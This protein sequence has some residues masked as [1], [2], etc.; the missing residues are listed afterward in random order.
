MATTV[1]AVRIGRVTRGVLANVL[2]QGITACTQ[3]VLVPIFLAH[4]GKQ[5]YGEWLTL[6]AFV[7]YLAIIDFGMQN[8]VVNRLNQCYV[9]GDM[10]E[11]R[12]VLHSA[13]SMSL[14][15]SITAVLVAVPVLIMAPIGKWFHF[16]VTGH[17][18]ASAVA[19]ILMFQVVGAVPNGLIGGIYRSV[20]EYPR[21]QMVTNGRN[22]GVLCL[23]VIAILA[24][25]GPL[26]VASAQLTALTLASA[27]MWRDLHVRHPEIRLGVRE[28]DFK[29]ARSFLGPS[30]LF[31]LIQVS[32]AL[33]VQGSAILAGIVLGAVSVAVF[34]P[35]RT[36]SNLVRQVIGAVF[37]ALWPEFTA[38][39]AAGEYP[40]LRKAHVLAAKLLVTVSGAAAVFLH[41]AGRDIVRLWTH[42]RIPY[43]PAL[44]DAFLGLVLF[45]AVWLAPSLVLASSNNHKQ[46]ALAN[47]FASVAGLTLGYLGLRRYGLSGLVYGIWIADSGVC[48]TVVVVK[49]CG[50]I[51]ER[52]WR[53]VGGV[54]MRGA[55]M[56]LC[57]YLILRAL[58]AGL[59]GVGTPLVRVACLGAAS[60]AA[61]IVL[62][63]VLYLGRSERSKVT[64]WVRHSASAFVG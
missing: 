54:P 15:F 44:M 46:M 30:A 34:V 21:G 43:D 28:A 56:L 48:G 8:F 26:G 45:Q 58:A 24:G 38:L 12:R 51:G 16:S 3:I 53:F 33:T 63:Y 36:L 61:A 6:S 22:L 41:F 64:D 2:G 59:A 4:W 1:Q 14:A 50:L 37:S 25:G 39:E 7:T 60:S 40:A 29:L 9:T 32:M 55:V 57:L 19:I 11:H 13:L 23:S 35:L 27:F 52:L 18:T 10:R 62:A 31:F 42:D 49:A 5:L 20:G 17:A 47:L